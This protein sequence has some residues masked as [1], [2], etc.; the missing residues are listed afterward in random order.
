MKFQKFILA[1]RGPVGRL[2]PGS[3]ASKKVEFIPNGVDLARFGK[4]PKPGRAEPGSLRILSIGRLVKT[5]GQRYLIEALALLLR[6]HPG[7][8]LTLVGQGPLKSRLIHLA[9]RLGVREAIDFVDLVPFEKIPEFIVDFDVL[10]MPSIVEGFNIVVLEAMASGLPVTLSDIS[11]F[12]DIANEGEAR[13]F[14][15][16]SPAGIADALAS[17]IADPQQLQE[18]S[19]KGKD[20]VKAYHWEQCAV[21]RPGGRFASS[22]QRFR[23]AGESS[24]RGRRRRS[25]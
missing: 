12:R 18:L 21:A 24:G 5:K 10:A 16:E 22:I 9:E 15:P 7:V 17:L 23:R 19:A 8:R 25:S 2:S 14:Q 13:F 4:I 11:G 3:E 6:T 1:V 20:R